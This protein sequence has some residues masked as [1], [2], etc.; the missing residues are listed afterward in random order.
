M[1]IPRDGRVHVHLLA[2]PGWAVSSEVFLVPF[3]DL[4]AQYHGIKSEIDAAVLAVLE[5]TQYVLGKYVV[6]FEKAFAKYSGA[7]EG[8]AVNSGTSALHVAL[9]AAGIGEG[10][11]VITTPFTFVATIAAIEYAR[12]KPVLV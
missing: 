11:E 8:I 12:A 1:P 9:L 4:K 10:D 3:L 6:N 7:A 5:S 2:W